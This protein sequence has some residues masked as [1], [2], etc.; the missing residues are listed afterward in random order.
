MIT[1]QTVD[2]IVGFQGGGLPVLSLYAAIEPG[3]SRRE[4]DSRVTS[5]LDQ[6]DSL[7]KDKS[8]GHDQRLSL[9]SDI[10]HIRQRLGEE[11]WPPAGIALFSCSGRGL[12]EEVTLPRAVRDQVVVDETAFVR[13]L[14]AVLEE[15]HRSCVVVVDK[16]AASA[17]EFYQDE[18]RELTEFRDQM[19]HAPKA[20]AGLDEHRVRDKAG[21]L[22]KRHY[23][24][25]AQTL[26][27]LMRAGRY[28]LLIIAGHE[29]EVPGFLEYLP[30]DLRDRVAG[31]F[32]INPD[33]SKLAEI[34]AGAS[35]VLQRWERDDE[36][37]TVAGV[38]DRAAAGGLAILG[39]ADC[40]WAGSVAAIQRLLVQDDV[41]M[42][43]VVCDEPRWLALSG[44]VSPLN[45]K[46]TRQTPDVINELVLAVID[47]GGS[48]KHIEADTPLREHGVAAEIRFPLPPEPTAPAG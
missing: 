39:P 27:E 25:V 40:L 38:L 14:L 34:H 35:A 4:I 2:R 8:A 41:T 26:G 46:P 1:A 29:A 6:A 28:E 22:V 17:W 32:T 12:Y 7:A 24:H 5:L 31:T 42:P 45:G 9:R 18:L 44:A 23:Q 48:V 3:I 37:R 33:G 47:E 10:E 36:E 20:V 43:G 11:D 13:P 15:Y 19:V 16:E 21:D 30:H